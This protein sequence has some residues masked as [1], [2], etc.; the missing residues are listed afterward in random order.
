MKNIRSYGFKTIIDK[1]NEHIDL[2]KSIYEIRN[3]LAILLI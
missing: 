2:A 1:I 3:P